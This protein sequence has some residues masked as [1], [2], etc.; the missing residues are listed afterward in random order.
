MRSRHANEGQKSKTAPMIG[1]CS[2]MFMPAFVFPCP[3]IV[4]RESP[5]ADEGIDRLAAHH[6]AVAVAPEEL[7]AELA[8]RAEPTDIRSELQV[9][10]RQQAVADTKADDR[11]CPFERAGFA[12]GAR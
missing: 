10:E 2:T 8:P 9:V 6:E 11:I 3:R 1:P 4:D 7:P 12:D 5:I